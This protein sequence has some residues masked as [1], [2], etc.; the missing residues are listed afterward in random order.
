MARIILQVGDTLTDRLR[1]LGVDVAAFLQ[2][3]S[4]FGLVEIG[5]GAARVFDAA[6]QLVTVSAPIG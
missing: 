6:L 3:A 4:Q 1:K 5:E 2:T